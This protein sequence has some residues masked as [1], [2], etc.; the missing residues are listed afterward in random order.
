VGALVLALSFAGMAAARKPRHRPGCGSACRQLGPVA[1][2]GGFCG[3]PS[4][5]AA[6]VDAARKLT[7]EVAGS[8]TSAGDLLIAAIVDDGGAITPP[9]GWKPVPNTTRSLSGTSRQLRVYYRVA[10][11]AQPQ[12]V[13][14]TWSSA[15]NA[16]GTLTDFAG[17]ST[18][19]PINVASG[20]ANPIAS[21]SVTAPSVTATS[22]NALLLFVGATSG[23]HK[24]T[25]PAGMT[26]QDLNFTG[27]FPTTPIALATQ[28]WRGATATGVRS[29][30]ISGP[31]E[32][33]GALIALNFPGPF[34]C[35][36]L[37]IRSQRVTATADGVFSVRLKCDWSAR[38]VGAFIGTGPN[39]E[40]WAASDIAIGAGKTKAIGVALTPA[41]QKAL[42]RLHHVKLEIFLWV[43][44][45]NGQPLIAGGGELGLALK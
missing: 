28:Q 43:I 35:P 20:Q 25:A 39:L 11:P 14:F 41:G 44:K 27:A 42:R 2:E 29:A 19:H 17:I 10:T 5:S 34:K 7:L 36:N 24:W 13:S 23:P 8:G 1:G 12:F 15:Q 30:K 37:R 40:R 3:Q 18:T 9:P 26:Q 4:S 32:S 45:A 21:A 16:F 6:S 31:S 38:C 33:A 22:A